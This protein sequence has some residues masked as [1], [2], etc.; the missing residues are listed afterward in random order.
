MDLINLGCDDQRD[1]KT[2]HNKKSFHG[3]QETTNTENKYHD[4]DHKTHIHNLNI[5]RSTEVQVGNS[6]VYNGPVTIKQFI[7]DDKFKVTEQ[8]K[9]PNGF[10]KR[11]IGLAFIGDFS[12][13]IPSKNAL[14]AAQKLIGQGVN[15]DYLSKNYKLLGHRQLIQTESPGQALYAEIQKW[16]HWT[17]NVH[18][19]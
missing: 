18:G 9:S 14:M 15:Q 10:N 13:I 11:S 8:F 12:K 1:P 6:L 5:E 17:P 19:D 7:V 3:S 16:P 2:T 4:T